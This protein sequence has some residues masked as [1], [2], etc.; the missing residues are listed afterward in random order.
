MARNATG[1]L[2]TRL[3]RN[4]NHTDNPVS[5]GTGLTRNLAPEV[6]V[7]D[8]YPELPRLLITEVK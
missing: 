3:L 6:S 5:A 4:S 8:L 7:D 2:P 1:P